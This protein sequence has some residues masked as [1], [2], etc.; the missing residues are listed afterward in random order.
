MSLQRLWISL[1]QILPL[2]WL[3]AVKNPLICAEN[4]AEGEARSGIPSARPQ[5]G[6]AAP[7]APSRA[8]IRD[9]AVALLC[10]KR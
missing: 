6:P 7:L 5:N 9:F 2:K 3:L 4:A 10:R 1:S 8:L